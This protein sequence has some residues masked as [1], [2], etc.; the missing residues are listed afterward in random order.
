[1]LLKIL[2]APAH[3]TVKM[4]LQHFEVFATAATHFQILKCVLVFHCCVT[5]YH[6]Y[7][8][9]KQHTFL[10]WHVL[11]VLVLACFTLVLWLGSHKGIIDLGWLFIWVLDWE[12]NLVPCSGD[13]WQHSFHE[14]HISNSLPSFRSLLKCYL[15]RKVCWNYPISNNASYWFL[16]FYPAFFNSWCCYFWP[17]SCILIYLIFIIS[18]YLSECKLYW[19]RTLLLLC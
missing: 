17:S 9:V 19:V 8:G 14:R 4:L 15:I 10:T 11:W 13:C 7:S 6:K 3:C 18:I 16:S 2:P 1:M 5:N 12:K